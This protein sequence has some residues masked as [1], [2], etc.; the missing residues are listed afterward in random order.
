MRGEVH[1]IERCFLYNGS[2]IYVSVVAKILETRQYNTVQSNNTANY[3]LNNKHKVKS[4]PNQK[5]IIFVKAKSIAEPL[6]LS[7]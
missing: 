5:N 1:Y 6:Y 4:I 2:F 7:H 3:N